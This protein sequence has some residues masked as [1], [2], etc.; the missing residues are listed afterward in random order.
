MKE[1]LDLLKK[2]VE[3]PSSYFEEEKIL[4]FV[5][6]YFKKEGIPLKR[7]PFH[8]KKVT[9]LKSENILLE[10]KGDGPGPRIHLNAHLDTVKPTEGWTRHPYGEEDGDRFYGIGALD[11]KA[12]VVTAML[13]V[14]KLHKKKASM[15]GSL[16]VSL[17]SG[18][19]GPFGLG[20]DALIKEGYLEDVDYTIVTE[21][22]A[23]FNGVGF[24]DLCLGARG[25]Y[26][27]TL[28]FR[29]KSSHA[30]TPHL[31]VSA[32]LDACRFITALE[33]LPM[34]VDDALGHSDVAVIHTFS[35]GG[36]C[37]TPDKATVGL[38]WHNVR[39]ETPEKIKEKLLHL[40]EKLSLKGELE[41]AFR[42]APS[43][44]T[45]GFMPYVVEG[46]DPFT[47]ALKDSIKEVT[48]KVPRESYFQSIGD[49]NYLGTRL[50]APCVIFGAMG[51]NFHGPDE[52]VTLSS[53]YAST[54][55][56]IHFL[57]KTL[58]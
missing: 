28:T 1:A 32:L 47:L 25:G 27:M 11:M 15:K 21:P 10:V 33:E 26:G 58:F 3:I 36:A 37:S 54:E 42:E 6:D 16:V 12:G 8:E 23:S 46:S 17:V 57:E 22:S 40:K 31:G 24:P 45:R 51:G 18:E 50:Q 44:E 56:V 14:K 29:G 35:D 19:E 20:T 4:D 2:L 49:F 34:E 7:I 13:A 38:F 9:G 53:L 5:E 43:E 30:A 52:Y 55:A 48:G 39:G 41:V